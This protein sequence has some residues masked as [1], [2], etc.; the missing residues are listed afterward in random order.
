MS[1]IHIARNNAVLGQFTEEDVRAGLAAGTY[2]G[3]DLAW[4]AGKK[5]WTP[6]ATWPEFA[7]PDTTP[8]VLSGTEMIP[9]PP[10]MSAT[11]SGPA[12]PAW[13]RPED[14]SLPARYF[15]SVKEILFKP[16]ATFAAIPVSGGMGRPFGFYMTTQIPTAVL[17]GVGFGLTFSGAGTAGMPPQMQA[18]KDLGPAAIGLGY[19]A[20]LALFAPI[21]LFVW[22]GIQHLL[23]K[24]WGA[25][26]EEYEATVRTLAYI[27]GATGLAMLPFSLLSLIPIVGQIFNLFAMAI[28]L[29]SLVLQIIALMKVHKADGGRV[30]GAVL[31]PMILVCCCCAMSFGMMMPALILSRPH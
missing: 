1:L 4:R 23:L 29:Y 13:E 10:P 14:G 7:A 27:W 24:A 17:M 21:G 19:F 18:L 2:L 26:N 12:M 16:T 11:P 30:T 8:P 22:S 28:G 6:L 5:D 20:S 9:Q 3:T 15:E 25:A 31:T